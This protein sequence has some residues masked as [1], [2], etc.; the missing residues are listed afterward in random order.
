MVLAA[1]IDMLSPMFFQLREQGD[2][3]EL[4]IHFEFDNVTFVLNALDALAGDNRFIAI[5]SRRPKHRTLTQIENRTETSRLEATQKRQEYVK[6][7]EKKEAE[8]EALLNKKM[9]DLKSQKEPNSSIDLISEMA[10]AMRDGQRRLETTR[11][12]LRRNARPRSQQD[13]VAVDPR[14]ERGAEP[15]EVAGG[16]VAAHSAVGGGLRRLFDP[17]LSRRAKAYRASACDR[18]SPSSSPFARETRS[19]ITC[20]KSFDEES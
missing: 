11:E 4:G 14:S 3:P 5:R 1:D 7:C 19:E 6:D 20:E 13:R 9:D 10:I 15:R 18:T 8:E 12:T 17:P 16:D 2:V